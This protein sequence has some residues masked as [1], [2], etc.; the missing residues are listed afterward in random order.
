MPVA[1]GPEDLEQPQ[2]VRGLQALLPELHDVDARAEHAVEEVG[3]VALFFAAVGTQVQAGRCQPA[4]QR[5]TPAFVTTCAQHAA[6]LPSG[7]REPKGAVPPGLTSE[8]RSDE[9]GEKA[10]P[11]KGAGEAG[12]A[13]RR[14]GR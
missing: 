12:G 7:P 10:V 5:V 9:G 6:I 14:V 3:Q 8:E 13:R 4:P 2:F 1:G 11:M